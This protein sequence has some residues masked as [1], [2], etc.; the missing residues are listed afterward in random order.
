MSS[1]KA[2]HPA[3]Q[4]VLLTDNDISLG[5][6]AGS[7]AKDT[8]AVQ[9]RLVGCEATQVEIERVELFEWNRGGCY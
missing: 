9:H 5:R 6:L 2:T 8:T 3:E 1:A 4:R 7:N